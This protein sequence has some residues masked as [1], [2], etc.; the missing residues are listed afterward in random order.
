MREP[1]TTLYIRPAA[2]ALAGAT[3]ISD[4]LWLSNAP[5][6][7]LCSGAKPPASAQATLLLPASWMH[8][9]R[10]QLPQMSAAKLA[11]ALP[12]ALEDYLAG[13]VEQLHIVNSRQQPDGSVLV[14]AIEP[15]LLQSVI[16]QLQTHDIK[17]KSAK[18][19]AL[20]LPWQSDSNSIMQLQED[21]LLRDH[22]GDAMC[23]SAEELDWLQSTQDADTQWHWYGS[24]RQQPP[25]QL[26]GHLHQHQIIEPLQALSAA[27]T[28]VELELLRGRF[29]S[30][31]QQQTRLWRPPAIAAAVLL[32]VGSGYA[33][34]DYLLLQDQL[35][36]HQQ[37]VQSLMRQTFPEITTIV[38]PRVQAERALA[39]RTGSDHDQL[40]R[41]LQ[42]TAP[43]I[44]AQQLTSLQSLEF[45]SEEL[46]LQLR[47][48]SVTRLDEML[49]Q[50]RQQGLQARLEGVTSDADSV[51][52]GVVISGGTN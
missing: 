8:I 32:L 6:A 31:E 12:F 3:A 49:L 26:K 23:L 37:Q 17:P 19:D 18:A 25:T 38:N 42:I 30:Q 29:S 9:R 4:W 39:A 14:A 5:Q 2:S 46:R 7:E 24:A 27:S 21:W 35:Q 45:A 50:L 11:Q 47:T 13:E 44:A 20:C 1:D 48:A 16:E 15:H 51:R 28:N 40:L 10:L 36:Q 33:I 41:L 34:S 43:V 52:A 22:R